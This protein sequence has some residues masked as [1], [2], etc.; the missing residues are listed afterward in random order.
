MTHLETRADSCKWLNNPENNVNKH[1]NHIEHQSNAKVYNNILEA[2]GHTPLVRLNKI[3][4]SFGLKC[5]ILVKCEYLNPGGS[6]KDRISLRMV[7]DAEKAQLIKPGYTLIEATSGNTGIGLSLVAAVKGYNMIITLP[8]KMSQEKVNVMKGLGAQVIRT[9]T[10]AAS[11]SPES[12]FSLAKRIKENMANSLILDQFSN[13]SNPLAH[14]DHTAAEIAEQCQGKLD[15][16]FAG[17]GTGGTMTGCASKLKEVFPNCKCIGVD[18]V[19][20]Q[21][22][23]PIE[24]NNVKTGYH[25]EGIGYDFIPNTLVRNFVDSWVK[26]HDKEAFDIARRL[27]KEEGLLVGG[28]SGSAVAGAIQYALKNNLDENHRLVVILPDSVRNYVN[29]FL[30]DDWMTDKG[31]LSNDIYLNKESKLYGKRVKELNLEAISYFEKNFTVGAALELFVKGTEIIPIMEDRKVHGVLYANKMLGPIQKKNLSQED[32]IERCISKD[33]ALVDINTDLSI[34]E[35]L[36][37]RYP[38]VL[39]QEKCENCEDEAFIFYALKGKDLL[40]MLN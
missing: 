30:D 19:G 31:F 24:L 23:E 27:I 7:E 34:V 9:P 32:T 13:L 17:T 38:V 18:P 1:A 28:S 40:K 39:V 36:L 20:S 15:F 25:I 3:P 35:K 11:S 14:Y 6:V 37:E 12:N 4:Q 22:A 21:M 33:Y 16:F 2:V 5:E 26:V 10:E 8:E 29:K